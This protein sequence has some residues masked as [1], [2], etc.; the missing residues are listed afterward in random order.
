ALVTLCCVWNLFGAPAVGDG[1]LVLSLALL[2]PFAIVVVVAVWHG[3]HLPAHRAWNVP[4]TD[5][6]LSTALLVAM[7]N[8]MGWDNASTIAR[9]VENPRRNY[10]RAM[11]ASAGIVMVTYV[12]P[13]AAMAWAGVPAGRFS[14]GSWADVARTMVGPWLGL[15]IVVGG[16]LTS[17]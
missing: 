9:E 4:G 2:S 11:L 8:Y 7:W 3:V 14:T 6:S 16:T 1:S 13:L 12:L 17:V 15:A 5:A 10:P